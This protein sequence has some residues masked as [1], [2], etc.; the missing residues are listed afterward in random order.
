MASRPSKF[1][2]WFEFQSEPDQCDMAGRPSKF[3]VWFALQSEPGQS[4]MASRPSKFDF[5]CEFQSKPGQRDMAS[6]PSKPNFWCKFQSEP[7][8]SDMARRPAKR[9]FWSF[10]Q[11]EPGQRDMAS[12]PPK[13][14]LCQQERQKFGRIRCSFAYGASHL[15]DRRHDADV[16]SK[17][18]PRSQCGHV[19]L[20]L[21]GTDRRRQPFLERFNHRENGGGPLGMV[22]FFPLPQPHIHSLYHV[23]IYWAYPL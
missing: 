11:S 22:L 9:D 14:D 19:R 12:R 3:D 2:F 23:G 6:R 7:G 1:D 5:W 21:F 18:T 15:G 20:K 13:F 17:R 10:F 8:Q 4:D 16:L